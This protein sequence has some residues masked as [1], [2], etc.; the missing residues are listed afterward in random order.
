MA[1]P[2]P[3]R[4]SLRTL[5]A[6]RRRRRNTMHDNSQPDNATTAIAVITYV[7][8]DE[9]DESVGADVGGDVLTVPTLL[10]GV[11]EDI[12]VVDAEAA[13]GV[14]VGNADGAAVG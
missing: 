3:P 6:W 5:E 7:N 4:P 8:I 9:E 2:V 12:V 10:I 1:I 14:W 13:V 11:E